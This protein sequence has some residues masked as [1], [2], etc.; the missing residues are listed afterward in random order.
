MEYQHRERRIYVFGKVHAN[1][2]LLFLFSS[3]CYADTRTDQPAL[4][5]GDVNGTNAGR[6]RSLKFTNGTTT[7]NGDGSVTVTSGAGGSGLWETNN[8]G[9]DTFNTVG[10]GSTNPGQK[11]DVV[12]T[13]RASL[14]LTVGTGTATITGDSNGNVGI[15]SLFPGAQLDV[16]G[17][18]R[19]NGFTM[20][21][22]ASSGYVLTTNGVGIGTWSPA[23]GGSGT[24]AGG[25]YS[26]QY[27]NPVGTFAGTE[28]KF[29]FNGTNVGIGTTNP[30]N[31]LD[32]RGTVTTRAFQI[33]P[34]GNVGL[35]SISPEYGLVV[36]QNG[37]KFVNA[38]PPSQDS[39]FNT[40]VGIGTVAPG[41]VLDV[42]GTLGPAVFNAS[43]TTYN[44]GIGTFT[45]GQKLDVQGTVRISLLGATLSVASGT[46][47]CMGQG[48]LSS[49]VVTITTACTPA[50][51]TGIF[52]TD[53]QSSITNVGSV[54]IATVTAGSSFV[55]QSTNVLD[56]SKVNWWIEKSS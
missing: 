49:G 15:G 35:G 43:T 44:V 14:G 5:I 2:I 38:S 10:I 36:S 26:V 34:N 54:T 31:L 3:I 6:Y 8:V 53:A 42:E 20:V 1:L 51:S 32:V 29:S 22:G 30:L 50:N 41:G 52:L 16:N 47:G 40:N 21:N 24:A 46:N 11:L 28:N 56:G 18:V 4:L 33:I 25:I 55:I 37:A 23:S 17:T 39:Y 27:N 19:M 12:G 7:N 45:P 13:I 9:I 48:T